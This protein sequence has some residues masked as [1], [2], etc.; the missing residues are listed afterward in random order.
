MLLNKNQNKNMYQ[1][2]QFDQNIFFILIEMN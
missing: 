2:N 1:F